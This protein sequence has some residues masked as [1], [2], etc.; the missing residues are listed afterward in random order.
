MK[1]IFILFLCFL[2]VFASHAAALENLDELDD[3]RASRKNTNTFY[4]GEAAGNFYRWQPQTVVYT[5]TT[6]GHEVWVLTSTDNVDSKTGHEYAHIPWSADGKRIAILMDRDT[7]SFSGEYTRDTYAWDHTIFTMRSDGSYL[8]PM[9]DSPA[10][11]TVRNRYVQWSPVD[12]DVYFCTGSDF[13]GQSGFDENA[14]YKVTVS[15]ESISSSLVVDIISGNTSTIRVLPKRAISSDGAYAIATS[16]LENDTIAVCDLVSGNLELSEYNMDRN[17]E[18]THWGNT[19]SDTSEWHDEMFSGN[20]EEGYW[21]YY[22]ASASDFW[23]RARPWG[24]DGNTPNHTV[25]TTSSGSPNYYDWF[26]NSG[27]NSTTQVPD[28]A[29]EEMQPLNGNTG[30]NFPDFYDHY[31]SHLCVSPWSDY[32]TFSDT[33]GSAVQPGVWHVGNANLEARD[34]GVAH[35]VIY[36]TWTGWTDVVT[37]AGGDGTIFYFERD[38][39]STY[40][41]ISDSHSNSP[42]DNIRP[43]QSPDGTKIAYRTDFLNPST[44]SGDAFV[45]VIHYP[46]PPEVTSCTATGGTGTVIT[47]FDWRTDQANP[48]TYTTLGWPDPSNDDPP[49]PRETEFFR[50]W[51][52]DDSGGACTATGGTWVPL[53]TIDADIFTRYDFSDGTWSGSSSWSITDTPG[54]GDWAYAVTSIEWSGLESHALSNIFTITVSSGSGTGSQD[55]TYPSSPGDL[56]NI[57]TSDFYTSFSTGNASIVR[58]YNI[59]AN[60]GSAPSVQQ[61]DLIATIPVNHCS[62]GS[63]RWVDWLGNTSETTEYVIAAVDTQGNISGSS[64]VTGQSSISCESGDCSAVSPE[65][66]AEGQYLLSWDD[67]YVA[68]DNQSGSTPSQSGVTMSG[69]AMGR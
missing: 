35:S 53:G 16:A 62:G 60:D 10:R 23:W 39:G 1:K 24:S 52:C 17:E 22:M 54:D 28:S 31:W 42:S 30:S 13:G 20:A 66:T 14:V 67:M 48:R 27:W 18:D 64:Y 2:I 29:S 7:S 40:T 45:T 50:L 44:S 57:S 11:T 46:H 69:A 51:R 59:Y 65:P 43:G 5:D 12:H 41:T 6:H 33:Q 47:R 25:D 61:Q 26:G 21:I 3:V 56:D 49:P 34:N 4:S 55:T 63:C 38:D 8:R 37:G 15:D 36:S 9:H 68:A 58:A 32:V 19:P